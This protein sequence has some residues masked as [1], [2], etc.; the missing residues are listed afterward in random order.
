VTKTFTNYDC[1]CRK[2]KQN[3][4]KLEIHC[5]KSYRYIQN[6]SHCSST[7]APSL[8]CRHSGAPSDAYKSRGCG[9]GGSDGW[10]APDRPKGLNE[11]DCW[12]S[13]PETF[14]RPASAARPLE[15]A[16]AEYVS[17]T[18]YVEVFVSEKY[19]VYITQQI[20]HN[21]L[22]RIMTKN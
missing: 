14:N 2:R 5:D 22:Q 7:E 17:G 9:G 19:S 8:T 18:A 4:V 16:E 15:A 12:A 21:K 10:L 1:Q 6:A 3:S 13:P 11:E 20:I